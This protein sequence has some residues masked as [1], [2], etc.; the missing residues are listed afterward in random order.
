MNGNPQEYNDRNSQ[1]I[2][3]K[4]K[5]LFILLLPCFLQAQQSLPDLILAYEKECEK[6]VKDTIEQNG[7]VSYE[8][9]PVKAGEVISHYVYGNADTVWNEPNCPEYKYSEFGYTALSNGITLGYGSNTAFIGGNP[10]LS[11]TKQQKQ[12][13]RITR[14]YVCEVKLREP[15]PFSEDFWNWLKKRAKG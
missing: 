10:I 3:F 4:M 11:S 1:L 13:V 14:Q 9:I 8:L 6:L 5:Y 15:E 7:V 2:Q 12:L